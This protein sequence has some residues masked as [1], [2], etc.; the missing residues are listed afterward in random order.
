MK[1]DVKQVIEK[2]DNNSLFDCLD[3]YLFYDK[4]PLP[5]KTIIK[6]GHVNGVD[7]RDNNE[8]M[9]LCNID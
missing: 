6:K 8:Y 9:F 1:F 5:N 3:G 4:A 7:M 2:Y